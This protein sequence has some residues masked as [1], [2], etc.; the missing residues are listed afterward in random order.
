MHRLN[1]EGKHFKVQGPLNMEPPPQGRPIISQAGESDEGRELAAATAD[2]IFSLPGNIEKS[3]E[4][5]ESVKGR[6]EKYGRHRDALKIMPAFK[7]IVGDTE[8]DARARADELMSLI[9]PELGIALLSKVFGDLSH[10]PIDKP[11]P[12]PPLPDPRVSSLENRI[13]ELALSGKTIRELY[14]F[15]G[16]NSVQPVGTAAEIADFMEERLIEG[17]ADG[18]NCLFPYVPAGA[19]LFMEKVVPI[20]Q[21]RGIFRSEYEGHTLREH[22]GLNY[23]VNRHLTGKKTGH[24]A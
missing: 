1:H 7:P 9:S 21:K 16:R 14:Q 17:V 11:I 3:R 4:Y 12:N 10:L 24:S 22:L 18:F 23:P 19:E 6:M 2:M 5:Y 20:L 13:R 15:S 8:S